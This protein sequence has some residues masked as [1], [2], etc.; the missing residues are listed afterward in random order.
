MYHE[1][2]FLKPAF[3]EKI[4]SGNKPVYHWQ[5]NGNVNMQMDADFLQVSVIN[6]SGEIRVDGKSFPIEK[7]V[8]FILPYGVSAF[9]LSGDAGMI[10]S[11]G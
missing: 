5:L 4:W 1:P 6:G 10:V 11:H 8:H 2:I 7:G 9:E 3:Q